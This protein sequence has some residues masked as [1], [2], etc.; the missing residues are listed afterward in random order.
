MDTQHFTHLTPD[1]GQVAGG[2]VKS[3]AVSFTGWFGR[4]GIYRVFGA[5]RYHHRLLRTSF[6]IDVNPKKASG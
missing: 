4:P 2:H 6:V 1:A 3:G 5:F